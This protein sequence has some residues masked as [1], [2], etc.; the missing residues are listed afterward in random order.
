MEYLANLKTSDDEVA[1]A[2]LSKTILDMYIEDWNDSSLEDFKET[3]SKTKS[4]IEEQSVKLSNGTGTNTL[5]FT[6]SDGQPIE[7]TYDSRMDSSTGYF[8][9]NAIES[10]IDEFGES[11]ETNQKVAIL[12]QT[13]EKLIKNK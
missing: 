10:A 2:R 6:G 8:L 9:E 1:V 7:R 5:Q 3:L 11:L 4:E 13:I 12:V